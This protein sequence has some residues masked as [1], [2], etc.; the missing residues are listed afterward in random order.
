MHFV[1]SDNEQ[2]RL[3]SWFGIQGR[4]MIQSR[5]AE[6]VN[7]ALSIPQP[8]NALN[9]KKWNK[10][11]ILCQTI[12][13]NERERYYIDIICWYGSRISKTILMIS[14]ISYGHI[15]AYKNKWNKFSSLIFRNIHQTEKAFLIFNFLFNALKFS[16]ILYCILSVH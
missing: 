9:G 13:L 16:N 6:N 15:W 14:R 10:K 8:E 3:Q 1:I 2:V 4:W 12:P 7:A 5:R 11:S